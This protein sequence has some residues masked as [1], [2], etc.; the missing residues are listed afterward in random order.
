[1]HEFESWAGDD[2]ITVTVRIDFYTPAQDGKFWGP[3][4]DSY[5]DEP[6]ELEFTVLNTD[7]T[8][9]QGLTEKEHQR[10]YSECLEEMDSLEELV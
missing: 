3:W 2:E 7:G 9:Y 8:P 4:E 10:I 6:A 5:P 1:M